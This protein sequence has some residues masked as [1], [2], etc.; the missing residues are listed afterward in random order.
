MSR[1]RR[2]PRVVLKVVC[3]RH[4]EEVLIQRTLDLRSGTERT[5]RR[6]RH[7]R[8]MSGLVVRLSTLMD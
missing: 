2:H 8:S 7:R 4:P 1:R 3:N 6:T 5:G